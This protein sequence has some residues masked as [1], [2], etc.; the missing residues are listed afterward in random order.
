VSAASAH[1]ALRRT[2]GAHPSGVCVVTCLDNSGRR[3]GVTISSFTSVSLEP[4]LV[5]WSL[6][7]AAPSLPAFEA[8]E[9]FAVNV[10]EAGQRELSARFARPAEDKFA[11]VACTEGLGGVPLLRGAAAWLE[12]S[13]YATYPGGDHTIVLGEVVRHAVGAARPLVFHGGEYRDLEQAMLTELV[14]FGMPA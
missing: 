4:P 12:C 7:N 1:L 14:P 6:S 9:R 13:R 3:C 2:L 10:L 11:G 8:A 5:L